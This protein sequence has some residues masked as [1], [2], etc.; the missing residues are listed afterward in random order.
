MNWSALSLI[1]FLPACTD[2]CLLPGAGIW[3]NSPDDLTDATDSDFSQEAA[4]SNNNEPAGN[5]DIK[6]VKVKHADSPEASEASTTAEAS[7]AS[8]SSLKRTSDHLDLQEPSSVTS[9]SEIEEDV[10]KISDPIT[11]TVVYMKEKQEF[12]MSSSRTVQFLKNRLETKFGVQRTAQKLLYKGLPKDESTLKDW[13]LKSGAKV[14]L[15]GSQ[16]PD[17]VRVSLGES[18]LKESS[19][20][21]A[22]LETKE[23]LSKQMPHRKVLEKGK[24][25]DAL[26]AF[27]N[28]TSNL[29][30]EPLSGMY[31]KKG[32]KVR[33][34]FKLELH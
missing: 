22:T 7:S 4:N 29:P 23:P 16:T 34:T 32:G 33:L 8:S 9:E 14:I 24:P 12:T 31:N 26:A 30:L 6:N 10:T 27:K 25:P 18:G 17:I 2:R 3:L 11:F 5:V 1:A 21:E 15:M 20:S 19:K 28:V 13:G